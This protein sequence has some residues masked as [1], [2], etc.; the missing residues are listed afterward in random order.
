MPALEW[1]FWLRYPVWGR[2]WCGL[3]CTAGQNPNS[4]PASPGPPALVSL[5]CRNGSVLVISPLFICFLL[6]EDLHLND[7][8]LLTSSPGKYICHIT[9]KESPFAIPSSIQAGSR[10][11]LP[12]PNWAE[13][14]LLCKG[15]LRAEESISRF[16]APVSHCDLLSWS[17]NLEPQGVKP[18]LMVSWLMLWLSS[19]SKCWFSP[20]PV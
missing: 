19:I 17:C 1:F 6:R 9:S 12:F 5:P 16:R 15:A 20:K 11:S 8:L 14:R 3:H 2:C 13:P 18:I 4:L 10:E 7:S